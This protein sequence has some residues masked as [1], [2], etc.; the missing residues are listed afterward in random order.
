MNIDQRLDALTMNVEL[1]TRD[2]HDLQG[3]VR[4]ISGAVRDLG[5]YVKDIAT[6]TARMS[7]EVRSNKD[8]LDDHERRLDSL[9]G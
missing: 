5:S 9:E 6:A 3:I 4:E 2:V 1:L 7:F 8:R